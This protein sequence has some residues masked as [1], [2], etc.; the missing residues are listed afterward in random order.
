MHILILIASCLDILCL[1]RNCQISTLF[2]LFPIDLNADVSLV[3]N[4]MA[5]V[6]TVESLCLYRLS[7]VLEKSVT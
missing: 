1:K 3:T 7:P 2:T 4:H 5:A 6:P